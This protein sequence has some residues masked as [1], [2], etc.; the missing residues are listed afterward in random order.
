MSLLQHTNLNLSIGIKYGIY[1]NINVNFMVYGWFGLVWVILVFFPRNL[2]LNTLDLAQ[3]GYIKAP[4]LQKTSPKHLE[5]GKNMAWFQ[6]NR[7]LNCFF[8]AV[9]VALLLF[10]LLQPY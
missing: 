2:V 10:W 6:I 5:D 4:N 8:G 9:V 3:I 1:R 7:I